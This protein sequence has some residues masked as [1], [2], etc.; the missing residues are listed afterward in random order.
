MSCPGEVIINTLQKF[1]ITLGQSRLNLCVISGFE[2]A[3][4]TF[5]WTMDAPGSHH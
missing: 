4:L 1:I 5:A 2:Y 3:S